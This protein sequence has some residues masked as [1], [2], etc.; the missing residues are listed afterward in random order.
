MR[1][2]LVTNQLLNTNLSEWG[3]LTIDKVANVVGGGTPKSSD[4]NNF[5]G[6]I[7]WITPKDLSNLQQRTV[8]RGQRNLSKKGLSACS[9]CVSPANSVLLSTRAPVGYLAISK[10]P[11]ATNQGIKSLIP[12]KGFD[13]QFLYYWLKSNINELHRHATGSTF[14]ELTAKSLKQI[15]INLPQSISEQR[16]ISHA[17]GALDDKIDVNRRMNHTLE[18]IAKALFKSWFIDFDPVQAKIQGRDTG[19]P[20]EIEDLFPS[21]MVDSEIGLI[22]EGWSFWPVAELAECRR[23][24]LTPYKQP[25][26]VFEYYS[27][28]AYSAGQIPFSELGSS[29]KSSKYLLPLN[30]VL[31]G[32][33]DPMKQKIWFPNNPDSNP[34]IAT[35]EFLPFTPLKGIGRALIYQLF[36]SDRFGSV[37]K[38]MVTGTSH[39]RV[40]LD[41]ILRITCMAGSISIFDKFERIVFPMLM[42]V[43]S[44]R[45]EIA[46]LVNL[47]DTLLPKLI[48][49]DLRILD[50]NQDLD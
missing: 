11:S 35:T 28:P 40:P 32:K 42:K 9:A 29:I 7:P 27:Y 38:G 25:D 1:K 33:L 18:S 47:R 30:S 8:S 49:G 6:N 20:K 50:M 48:S 13:Y 12:R 10:N 4:P 36:K 2:S 19:L 34:Q 39:Q 24:N 46:R 16:V 31:L 22:P 17:L 5:S 14:Q 15:Q 44:N 43:L 45:M 21:Q 26:T 23:K 37:Y 3:F 41:A